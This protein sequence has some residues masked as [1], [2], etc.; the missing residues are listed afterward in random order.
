MQI[1]KY[2][3]PNYKVDVDDYNLIFSHKIFPN[4]NGQYRLSEYYFNDNAAFCKEI[5]CTM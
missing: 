4:V 1:H 3:G 5:I 2:P